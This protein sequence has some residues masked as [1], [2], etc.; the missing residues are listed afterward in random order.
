MYALKGV[1]VPGSEEDNSNAMVQY[2]KKTVLLVDDNSS[3]LDFLKEILNNHFSDFT[4]LTASNGEEA[5]E[6]LGT[7]LIHYM[8]CDIQMPQMSGFEV[9][10]KVRT[11]APTVP[12][13]LMTAD[14]SNFQK[15]SV[16]SSATALVDKTLPLEQILET[17]KEF[18]ATK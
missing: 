5:L 7:N 14:T 17:L 9:F 2:V 8:I 10:E 18:L 11:L 13:C 6:I 3:V 4:I 12:V 1:L 16:V 15:H